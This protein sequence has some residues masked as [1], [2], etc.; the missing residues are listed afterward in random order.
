MFC[1]GAARHGM[2]VE[3]H[4]FMFFLAPLLLDKQKNIEQH[5][6]VGQRKFNHLHKRIGHRNWPN[7]TRL[8]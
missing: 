1:I 6:E 5:Y 2:S 8:L 3:K 4:G 7:Q